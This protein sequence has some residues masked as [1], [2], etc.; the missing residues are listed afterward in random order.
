MAE[1]F[2]DILRWISYDAQTEFY[3]KHFPSL[4]ETADLILRPMRRADLKIVQAIEQAAYEF[5]WEPATF[6]DCYNVGYNCWIAE[7]AGRV[8]GYGI[9]SVGA[10]EAHVLNLCV[11]PGAQGRGYG[12]L[13]LEKLIEVAQS[14]RAESMFLEVRPTNHHAL[15]LYR[16][17]GFNEIGTRKDYYPAKK[18]REDAVVMALIL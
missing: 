1:L 8:V 14:F 4:V 12:R 6:R 7:K 16:Q 5:P 3:Y 2:D 10:G 9:C 15:K 11:S 18:G 17:M 13:M